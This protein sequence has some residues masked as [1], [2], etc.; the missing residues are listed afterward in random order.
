MIIFIALLTGLTATRISAIVSYD[1]NEPEIYTPSIN[2]VLMTQTEIPER[3]EPEQSGRPIPEWLTGYRMYRNG[4]GKSERTDSIRNKLI[5]VFDT[6]L[7]DYWLGTISWE[8]FPQQKL[9][10]IYCK[11]LSKLANQ[12]ATIHDSNAEP[13]IRIFNLYCSTVLPVI[14]FEI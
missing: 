3:V 13:E 8:C 9:I 6:C 1:A 14:Y 7:K 12:T 10:C 4:P 11:K 5:S 2:Q